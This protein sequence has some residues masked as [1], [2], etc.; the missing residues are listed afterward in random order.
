MLTKA[1]NGP[2]YI[3][4]CAILLQDVSCKAQNS[5]EC[6]LCP[7]GSRT[8]QYKK[9]GKYENND[10]PLDKRGILRCFRRVFEVLKNIC[11]SGAFLFRL[12]QEGEDKHEKKSNYRL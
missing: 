6:V 1:A 5:F 4:S 8:S 3:R 9:L 10:F 7:T 2:K 12:L 11:E